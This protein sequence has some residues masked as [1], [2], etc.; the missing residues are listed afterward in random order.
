MMNNGDTPESQGDELAALIRNEVN[1][2]VKVL[3]NELMP[4]GVGGL[5]NEIVDQVANKI[6]PLL[7]SVDTGEIAQK[8]LELA[9]GQMNEQA[10]KIGAEIESRA[11]SANGSGGMGPGA[12]TTNGHEGHDHEGGGGGALLPPGYT[13]QKVG[14][15]STMA[16]AMKAQFSMDPLGIMNMLFDKVFQSMEKWVTL[17]RQPND[18]ET[19]NKIQQRA[20]ALF[21]MYVPNPWGPEFQRMQMETWNTAIKTK[22]GNSGEQ[23]NPGGVP[24]NPFVPGAPPSGGYNNVSAAPPQ[25]PIAVP[26]SPTGSDAQPTAPTMPGYATPSGGPKTMATML[27]GD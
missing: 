14:G 17:N 15:A 19:L 9:R 27:G 1:N 23:T 21:G 25:T 24:W 20:P 7:P 5:M 3:K 22:M 8:T 2:Q 16:Q 4:N 18:V 10:E 11:A 13:F 6:I 26:G 12:P